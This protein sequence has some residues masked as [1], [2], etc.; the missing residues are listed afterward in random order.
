MG[1]LG[2]DIPDGLQEDMKAALGC[3]LSLK[4]YGDLIYRFNPEILDH[5]APATAV[6]AGGKQDDVKATGIM[7]KRVRGAGEEGLG[8]VVKGMVHAWDLQDGELFARGVEAWVEGKE[9]PVEFVA[10]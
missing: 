8:F 5:V 1:K 7:G 4:I 6:I 3:R 2:S 9:M 10:L